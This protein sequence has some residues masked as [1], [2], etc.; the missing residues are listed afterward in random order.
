LRSSRLYTRLRRR[1]PV[2]HIAEATLAVVDI[3]EHTADAPRALS[4]GA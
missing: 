2:G 1:R 4:L 3:D